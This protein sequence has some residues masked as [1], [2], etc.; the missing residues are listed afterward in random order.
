[1]STF[2]ALAILVACLGLLGLTSFLTEQRKREIGIRKV[3]AASDRDIVRLLSWDFIK[4]VL[5]GF[6]VTVPVAWYVAVK[7]LQNFAYRTSIDPMLFVVS[8]LALG[9]LALVTVSYQ[10]YKNSWCNPV[11]VL[12]DT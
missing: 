4:L 1:M 11:D 8:G 6:L 9:M 5:I 2:S 10:S 12:K 3:H 7:W